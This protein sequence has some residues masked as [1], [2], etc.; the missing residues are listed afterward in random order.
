MTQDTQELMLLAFHDRAAAEDSV[1]EALRAGVEAAHAAGRR[2]RI[3]L[4]GGSS[5]KPT[6]QKFAACDLDWS[7]VDIALVDDRWVNLD[8]LGSNEAMIRDA[9]KA[10]I[11]VTIFGMKTLHDT[12]FEAASALNLIYKALRPFDTIVLG[13]GPDAHTASWFPGSPQLTDCLMMDAD[14]T[15]IGVDA[16]AAPV[17]GAYPLR[18]TLTLPPVGEAQ[19]V[20]LLLF[21]DDKK[22]VLSAAVNTPAHKAPIRAAVEK[23]GDRL[24]VFWAS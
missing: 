21:G 14:A 4:S 10:A 17:S 16:S 8:D 3:A 5:P 1:V 6:Y 2:A 20:I 19:Q 15:V 7:R 24:V 12:P 22:Q 9:F 11:G 23:C 18:M 13:M